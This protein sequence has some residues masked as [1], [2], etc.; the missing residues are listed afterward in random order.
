[1][2]KCP[3]GLQLGTRITKPEDWLP[4]LAARIQTIP[5]SLAVSMTG[6]ATWPVIPKD[7]R[8]VRIES[9]VV[10]TG[11]ACAGGRRVMC[12]FYNGSTISEC[13][14]ADL[15]HICEWSQQGRKVPVYL[16]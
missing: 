9:F 5:D 4:Y 1:M 3:V 16:K 6:G 8:A 14:V 10:S 12:K 11:L 13:G 7:A 2:L 15:S